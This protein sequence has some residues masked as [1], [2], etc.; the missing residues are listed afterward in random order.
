MTC[1]VIILHNRSQYRPDTTSY[2][3]NIVHMMSLRYR[4]YAGQVDLDSY[5]KSIVKINL[6]RCV[7]NLVM[8]CINMQFQHHK[9]RKVVLHAVL[10]VKFLDLYIAQDIPNPHDIRCS[11][12]VGCN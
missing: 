9:L 3:V 5:D 2:V 8:V 6:Y 1:L 11:S 12:Q 7:Q 10:Y 4:K